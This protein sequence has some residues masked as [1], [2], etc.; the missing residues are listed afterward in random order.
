MYPCNIFAVQYKQVRPDIITMDIIFLYSF[1]CSY[2]LC[3]QTLAKL[4]IVTE[5]SC[6]F[7]CMAASLSH[8]LV[9]SYVLLLM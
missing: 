1:R 3:I 4:C 7:K 5:F 6:V 8:L 2:D 9:S